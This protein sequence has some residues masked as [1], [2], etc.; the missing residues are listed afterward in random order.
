LEDEALP[1]E[2]LTGSVHHADLSE[3]Y[4]L[5]KKLSEI[6]EVKQKLAGVAAH[7]AKVRRMMNEASVD[8]WCDCQQFEIPRGIGPWGASAAPSSPA[9]PPFPFRKDNR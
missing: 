4:I 8:L 7:I 1:A 9:Q 3:F 6:K 2:L 5:P